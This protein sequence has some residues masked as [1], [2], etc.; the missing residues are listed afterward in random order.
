MGTAR[1]P[2]GPFGGTVEW[3]YEFLAHPAGTEVVESYRA[4]KPV[5]RIGWMIISAF[6]SKDR[7]SLQR[8]GMKRTLERLRAC[9]EA[10]PA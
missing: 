3:T 9:V 5:S 10:A 4:T 6:S 8:E 1:S 7:R 2:R